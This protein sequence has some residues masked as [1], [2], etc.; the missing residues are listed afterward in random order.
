M[1]FKGVTDLFLVI[2]KFL[3]LVLEKDTAVNAKNEG[4]GIELAIVVILRVGVFW[5]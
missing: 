2:H 3:L 4:R 5:R 1:F